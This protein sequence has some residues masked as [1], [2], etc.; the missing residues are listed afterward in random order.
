MAPKSTPD[1]RSCYVSIMKKPSPGLALLLPLLAIAFPLVLMR[2]PRARG[3]EPDPPYPPTR[4]TTAADVL[5]GVTVPDPYRWLEDAKSP[6]VQA[7]MKA[8]DDLAR[9]VSY[10]HLTLPT[11]YSV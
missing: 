11:I 6:E 8:E 2:P 9:P 1:A 4:T 10:T 5:H 3:A 7:W